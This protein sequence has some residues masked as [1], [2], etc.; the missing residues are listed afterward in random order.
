MVSLL[1]KFMF[2]I[3]GETPFRNYRINKLIFIRL[4]SI[5]DKL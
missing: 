5:T 2:S 4:G 1:R 3:R